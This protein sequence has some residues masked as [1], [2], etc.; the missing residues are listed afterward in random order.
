MIS[1]GYK[2]DVEGNREDEHGLHTKY[3]HNQVGS[4]PHDN[5]SHDGLYVC[6]VVIQQHMPI[7]PV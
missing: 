1:P 4:G 5:N 2:H 3:I 7:T 6:V